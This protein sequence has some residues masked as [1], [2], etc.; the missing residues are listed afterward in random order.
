MN[1]MHTAHVPAG[2]GPFPTILALH[3]WGANAHDLL[4]LAP[5]LHGGQALVL[6]PQGPVAFDVGGGMPG[7][8]WFPITGGAPPSPEEFER[9]RD[10]LLAFLDAAEKHYPV[11]RRKIVVMGFSQGGVMAYD[12]VLRD[13]ERFC[14]LVA[15][16][17]WY[18]DLV[19][20][21]IQKQDAHA[22]FPV[23][24]MHGT[25]DPMIPVA[26]AQESRDA[27]LALDMA[28]AYHEYEMGHEIR[29]E[30]LRDLLVWLEEKCLTT[31][32]LA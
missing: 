26:R 22:N 24:V 9:G 3:G 29:P 19:G 28:L 14:G 15:M 6:A 5:L 4:G 20:Q 25:E 10:A 17:S 32:M 7:Y 21:A 18:P 27:L 16:S 11:D 23:L 12:L 1:L 30:A 31:I 13:P 8:G 2:D